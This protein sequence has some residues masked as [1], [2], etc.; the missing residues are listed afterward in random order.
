MQTEGRGHLNIFKDPIRNRKRNFESCGTMP[1]P[2]APSLAPFVIFLHF[3]FFVCFSH[4]QL[5]SRVEA[6]DLHSDDGR[7]KSERQL[8]LL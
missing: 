8:R 1:Q 6:S 4:G 3:Y 5:G 7:C 2:T